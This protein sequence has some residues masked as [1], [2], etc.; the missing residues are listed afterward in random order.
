M[1]VA[2]LLLALTLLGCGGG[3][4]GPHDAADAPE[5]AL[6]DGPPP[7]W[8]AGVERCGDGV[9]NDGDGLA[10][11]DCPPRVWAGAFP[12]QGGMDLQN[13]R[14]VPVIEADLGRTLAVIQTYH[15]TSALGLQKTGPDL[16]AIWDHGAIPHL[17]LEP[18]LYTAAQYANAATDPTIDAD[19]R[20]LTA[21]L[22]QSLA[23]NPSG[24]MLFTFGAEM[25][26]NW[27][28]WGCLPAASFIALYRKAHD[29]VAAGLAASQP[30]IDP[31]RLRWVYG[32][33]NVSYCGSS[34][35]YYPGHDYVDYLGMS[36]Y[37]AG[38]DSVD[39]VV[40][41]PAHELF[42]ALAFPDAWREDRF[43][44]L[45]TGTRDVAGDDRGAWITELYSALRDDPVFQG[46]IWFHEADWSLITSAETLR[47]YDAWVAVQAGL[48]AWDARLDATFEPYFWD[49][50]QPHAYYPE[51]QA[52]R[53]AGL[54]SGCSTAPPLFCAGQGLA[55]R[56]AAVLLA[57]AF[58][59]APDES[60]PA[61]FGDVPAA[62]GGYGAI[63]ALAK[64]GALGGCTASAFCPAEPIRRDALAVALA[65]LSGT[66]AAGGT[67]AFGD[68]GG[69]DPA[70]AAAIEALARSARID[71][72]GP[73]AFCPAEPALRAAGAAW[74]VRTAG[75]PPAPPLV[76]LTGARGRG[77]TTS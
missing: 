33:N 1:R 56:D 65:A 70:T 67:G 9:D 19:L 12:P 40:I 2:P 68:L 22:V 61:L 60:E 7:P 25:N 51:V 20:A 46:A 28:P 50:R 57:G 77:M 31:R 16:Q 4:A 14:L 10:D 63:Q 55:R 45:Q 17:N 35:G 66:G 36:S 8:S 30:P 34:A 5:A 72:C 69:L 3:A 29:L 27:T 24:R 71:G 37:R 23:A 74:I 58:G 44:L 53:A 52:L 48:P 18:E 54:T 13:A 41:A 6:P 62:A 42:D 75:I 76:A 11:E 49:V 47:G 64:R 15:T 39:E 43:I 73:G 32:P 59:L 21:T 38:T 26:G